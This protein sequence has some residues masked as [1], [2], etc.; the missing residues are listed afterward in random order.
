MIIQ[1]ILGFGYDEKTNDFKVVRI[2]Y[3][4]HEEDHE[5]SVSIPPYAYDFL[6]R[7]EIFSVNTKV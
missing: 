6:S 7:V 2:E 3:I 5:G 1:V 4:E